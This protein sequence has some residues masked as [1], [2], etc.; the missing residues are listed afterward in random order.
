MSIDRSADLGQRLEQ[1]PHEAAVVLE[2]LGARAR[3]ALDEHA[4]AGRRLGHL[5]DDRDR[6]DAVQIVGAPA[7]RRRR[8]A[9]AAAPCG[10]RRARG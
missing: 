4:H 9:A 8:A 2:E 5:P 7:R 6:A 10:R 1:R 3:D